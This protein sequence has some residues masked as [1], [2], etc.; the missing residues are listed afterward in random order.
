MFSRLHELQC[1]E[2]A[3]ALFPR[4]Q[5][6]TIALSIAIKAISRYEEQQLNGLKALGYNLSCLKQL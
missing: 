1:V 4:Q 2:C 5:L 3:N 6:N